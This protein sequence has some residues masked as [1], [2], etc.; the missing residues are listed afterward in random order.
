MA[1]SPHQN[2][3]P[4]CTYDALAVRGPGAALDEDLVL[5]LGAHLAHVDGLPLVGGRH[6]EQLQTCSN[7]HTD[8]HT[9]SENRAALST[10]KQKVVTWG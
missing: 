7:T 3:I 5:P 8:V 1:E 6:L 10:Q 4:G 9:H 2:N